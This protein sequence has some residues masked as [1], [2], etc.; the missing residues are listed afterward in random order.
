MKLKNQNVNEDGTIMLKIHVNIPNEEPKEE[1]PK[2][3][4]RKK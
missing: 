2:K 4:G 3:K 1:K